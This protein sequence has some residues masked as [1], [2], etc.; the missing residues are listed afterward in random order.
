V[1]ATLLLYLS[2]GSLPLW[3]IPLHAICQRVFNAV[4]PGFGVQPGALLT[5]ALV[6]VLYAMGL[7]LWV[8]A[9]WP[10]HDKM[11]VVAGWLF[12]AMAV[13]AMAFFYFQFVNVALTSIHMAVL[14]RILW[15]GRLSQDSLLAEYNQEHMVQERLRRLTQL[16]Q[17]DV[18]GERVHLRSRALLLMST[19][20]YF[21]RHFLGLSTEK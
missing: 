11:D 5:T 19:P 17:I 14:L 4:S 21:W 20:V 2:I 15:A 1:W 6:D 8:S 7:L 18:R 10:H 16:R 13:N 3:M 12:V 9:L